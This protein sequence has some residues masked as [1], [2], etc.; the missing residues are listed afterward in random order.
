MTLG[1]RTI[2][3]HKSHKHTREI[4]TG[5]QFIKLVELRKNGDIVERTMTKD[6]FIFYHQWQ[7]FN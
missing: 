4:T 5:N 1:I 3:G 6:D 7:I 2:H